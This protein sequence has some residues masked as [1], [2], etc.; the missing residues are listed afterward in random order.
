MAAE[1][2]YVAPEHARPPARSNPSPLQRPITWVVWSG[3]QLLCSLA[4]LV[5]AAVFGLE[6]LLPW[7]V[8]ALFILQW[9]I[10]VV[11]FVAT[12]WMTDRWGLRVV[13]CVSS[14]MILG[15]TALCA[16]GVW[17]AAAGYYP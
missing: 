14:L 12:F 2:P 7:N 1:N 8:G 3:A 4:M 5:I 17:M 11:A 15:W 9:P 13:G 10:S 16:L 6:P